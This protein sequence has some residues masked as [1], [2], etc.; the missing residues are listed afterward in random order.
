MIEPNRRN[1]SPGN[2]TD[3]NVAAR[4]SRFALCHLLRHT[5]RS[6]IDQSTVVLPVSALPGLLFS[7]TLPCFGT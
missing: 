6:S 7:K 3:F 5:E 4:D 2:P 1:R